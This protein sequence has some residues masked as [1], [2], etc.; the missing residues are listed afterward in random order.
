MAAAP[1]NAAQVRLVNP[2]STTYIKNFLFVP[3]AVTIAMADLEIPRG[4]HEV[5]RETFDGVSMR[6]ITDYVVA[7][8]QMITRLDVLYGYKW[9]RPEWAVIIADSVT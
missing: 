3:D 2:A 7:T 5:A 8:D 4:V 9:L 1:G 6:M